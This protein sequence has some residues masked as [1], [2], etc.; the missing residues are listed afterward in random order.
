MVINWPL[1]ADLVNA[2]FECAGAIFAWANVSRIKEDKSVKGVYW[3]ASIVFA[4]WGYW[5][6]IYYPSLD[7]WFSAACG[8]VLAFGNTIWVYHAAKYATGK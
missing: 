6:M 4:C 2:G 5:N 1:I 7:Q 3:P 8:A